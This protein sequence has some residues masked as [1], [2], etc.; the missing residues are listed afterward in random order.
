MDRYL[1][2]SRNRSVLGALLAAQLVLVGYQV[3]NPSAGGVRLIRQWSA[4]AILPVE[5]VAQNLV[6]SSGTWMASYIDLRH[7]R[8]QNQSL[9][10]Q[11]GTLKLTN[12]QLRER[13]RELPQLEALLGFQRQYPLRTLAAE[14]ISSGASADAQAIYLDR[15]A[16][17]GVR[18]NMAVIT[19]DGVV[20]KVSQVLGHSAQVMLTT[21]PDSGVGAMIGPAGVHGILRGLGAGRAEVRNVLKDEPT[22]PGAEVVTSGEDQVFPKGLPL[23]VVT[24]S[25]PSSDGV[26]KT[27]QIR[28]AA[29]MGRLS[30]VLIVTGTLPPL[31]GQ[32]NSGLTAAD[33]RERRLPMLPDPAAAPAAHASTR[34][35]TAPAGAPTASGTAAKPAGARPPAPVVKAA[36][37]GTGTATGAPA[38][39][40]PLVQP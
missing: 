9:Q 4:E 3:R 40:S 5:R 13:L 29:H 30:N 20:G 35:A 2:R 7:A 33:I 31:T 38:V 21:D 36:Q 16:G 12:E 39:K 6:G 34:G 27:V 32:P 11:V 17:G 28:L 24:G 15:G 14:V 8:Q 26:F 23:G 18:R 22:P 37:P 19:P 25:K 10:Q 1:H